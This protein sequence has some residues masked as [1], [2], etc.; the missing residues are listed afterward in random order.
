MAVTVSGCS[1]AA[2]AAVGWSGLLGWPVLG[3]PGAVFAQPRDDRFSAGVRSGGDVER[4]VLGVVG[5]RVDVRSAREQELGRPA[6]TAVAGL[7]ERVVDLPLGGWL[8][9]AQE[10]LRPV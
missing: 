9:G 7:P 10:F 5:D 1:A 2:Q 6:L 3:G 8:L 4:S